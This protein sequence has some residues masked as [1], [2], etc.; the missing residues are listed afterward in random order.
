MT[1]IGYAAE[2]ALEMQFD[3]PITDRGQGFRQ[4]IVKLNIDIERGGRRDHRARA[5]IDGDLMSAYPG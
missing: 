4:R 3:V 1:T 2:H 5:D